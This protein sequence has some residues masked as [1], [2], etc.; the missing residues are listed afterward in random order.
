MALSNTD[1]GLVLK[2]LSEKEKSMDC[3]TDKVRRDFEKIIPVL[4][5]MSVSQ[6]NATECIDNNRIT[7]KAVEATKVVSSAS[8]YSPA[9][10]VVREFIEWYGKK[11]NRVIPDSAERIDKMEQELSILRRQLKNRVSYDAEILDRDMEIKE[12]K[13]KIANLIDENNLLK[14]KVRNLEMTKPKKGQENSNELPF[15]LPSD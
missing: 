4:R 2:F 12:L 7:L 9:R 11:Y 15:I 3:L 5:H 6:E 1:E 13:G 14:K 10:T 8:L